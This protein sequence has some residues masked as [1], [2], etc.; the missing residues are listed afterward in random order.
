[1]PTLVATPWPSG[2]VVVSTPGGQRYSGWPGHWLSSWRKFLMSSS[3]TDEL[4]ERL[5]LRVDRLDAGEVQQ[6]VEQHRR[7]AGRE[8]EAVA[9]RPDRVVRGRSG[10]TAARGVGHRRQRHRRAR[11]ARVRLLHRV[12]RQR[13]DRVDGKLIEVGG[14]HRVRELSHRGSTIDKGESAGSLTHARP[15]P[16]FRRICPGI[17]LN[18]CHPNADLPNPE[19]RNW[20]W[21]PCE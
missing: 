10:G 7:V 15:T 11:V 16:A 1:M 12:H 14:G 21:R 3:G 20:H 6:R 13:A 18:C 19:T 2:P 4:A 5:V 17:T 8:H 9:V